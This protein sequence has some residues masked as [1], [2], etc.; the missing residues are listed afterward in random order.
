MNNRLIRLRPY[1]Y[2]HA[3]LLLYSL[4]GVL[5]K[6]ASRQVFMSLPF[7]LFYCG[8]LAL[9]LIYAVFWQQILKM[10]P[11][12]VAFANKAVTLF[13]G[14]LWGMLLFNE[15][16]TWGMVLGV[17]LVFAGILLVVLDNE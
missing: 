17:A 8:M 2:L 5:S 9:L 7:M 4:S 13:W 1:I 15:R 6:L 14:I 12:S 16:L 10:L 3:L 11:L